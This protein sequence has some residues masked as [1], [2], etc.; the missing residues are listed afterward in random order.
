MLSPGVSDAAGLYNM[1]TSLQ[2]CLGVG[3]GPGYHA[4]LMLSPWWKAGIE[5]KTVK[6]VKHPFSPPCASSFA[7]PTVWN[8]GHSTAGYPA[9]GYQPPVSPQYAV[10]STM[11][12]MMAPMLMAP[13]APNSP[14]GNYEVIPMPAAMP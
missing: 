7:A 14:S 11:Q 13:A 1:P 4:P 10:G 5:A 2:Q 3:V 12:P 9:G 8:G 6:R